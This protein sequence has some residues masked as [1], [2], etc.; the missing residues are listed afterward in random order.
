MNSSSG[1]GS[2]ASPSDDSLLSSGNLNLFNGV[3]SDQEASIDYLPK[4]LFGGRDFDNLLGAEGNDIFYTSAGNDLIKGLG[5]LDTLIG[6]DYMNISINQVTQGVFNLVG[7]LY[8]IFEAPIGTANYAEKINFSLYFSGIEIFKQVDEDEGIELA[9]IVNPSNFN[10]SLKPF[11]DKKAWQ[12][13]GLTGNDVLIGGN[14]AD[15]IRGGDGDDGE[16][17]LVDD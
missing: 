3:D 10:D 13:D 4:I 6:V 11:D 17:T 16:P 15:D 7:E 1:A 9:R 14:S 2:G 12:V 5:G 8:E